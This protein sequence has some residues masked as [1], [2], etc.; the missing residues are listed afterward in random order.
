MF[1]YQFKTSEAIKDC[2]TCPCILKEYNEPLN[3]THF[4]CRITGN[5][6]ASP[7]LY[8]TNEQE[9]GLSFQFKHCPLLVIR[10]LNA[11]ET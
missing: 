4:G 2:N 9:N 3:F 11:N 6:F 5:T 1:T 8:Y 10:R 7:G